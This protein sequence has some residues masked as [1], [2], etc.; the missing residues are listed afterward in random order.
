MASRRSKS[1]KQKEHFINR[2]RERFFEDANYED[3]K[4]I[5]RRIV[6]GK[7]EPIEKQSLRMKLHLVK[8]KGHEIV[9]AYDKLRKNCVTAMPKEYLEN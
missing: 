1:K 5:K 2:L 6:E 3:V 9:V 7:S 8:Y 4:N